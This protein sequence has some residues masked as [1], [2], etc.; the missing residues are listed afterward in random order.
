V[1]RVTQRRYAPEPSAAGDARRLTQQ[2]L[3]EWD[4]P[5]VVDDAALLVSEVVTNAVVHARSDI[6]FTLAV[7]EGSVEVGVADRETRQPRVRP[8]DPGL[9]PDEWTWLSTHG[10]GMVLVDQIADE[11]GVEERV[12]GKQIWFRLAA[13]T[14]W[15]YTPSCLCR[16]DESYAVRLGSGRRAVVTVPS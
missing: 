8:S 5:E 1:C 10:R 2:Q 14:T 12:T 3:V 11:W 16:E 9:Q 15:P 4:L 6:D 13:P 7:A